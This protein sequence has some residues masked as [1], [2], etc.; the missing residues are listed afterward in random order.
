ME[1]GLPRIEY[2]TCGS[3]APA[4]REIPGKSSSYAKNGPENQGNLMLFTQ[5]TAFQEN[6]FDLAEGKA[7]QAARMPIGANSPKPC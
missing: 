7:E 5:Q 4:S 3:S 6:G 2:K 1:P